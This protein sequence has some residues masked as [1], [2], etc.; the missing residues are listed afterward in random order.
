[1]IERLLNKKNLIS[2]GFF[3]VF[4]H[5]VLTFSHYFYP[6][7]WLNIVDYVFLGIMGFAA[8]LFFAKQQFQIRFQPA[9]M[10]L[11]AFIAWYIVSCLSMTITFH[12]DWV[13]YNNSGLL[14][15]AV[16]AV[17]AFSLGYITIRDGKKNPVGQILLHVLMLGWTLFIAY[18]LIVVFQGKEIITAS[19][20]FIGVNENNLLLNCNRNTT[21]AWEMLF[22]MGCCFMTMW[23]KQLPLKI[24]YGLSSAIH[25]I[26]LTLSNSRASF[27]AALI[28]FM[29]M[30][31]VAVYLRLNQGGKPHKILFAVVAAL[32]A[33]V[34]YYFVSNLVYLLYNLATGAEVSGRAFEAQA[35]TFSGREDVWRY[36]IQGIFSSLRS[37]IFGVTPASV[38][39]LILQISNY[40][41]R[42]AM[43]THN[44]FLEIAA[45]IGIP[46]LCIFLVWFGM[47]VRDSFKLYFVQ[48]DTTLMLMIPII[49]MALMLM[50]MME[51]LLVFYD[52]IHHYVFFLLCGL[53]YGR[54]NKP[55]EPKTLSRQELRNKERKKK[56]K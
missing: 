37:A 11:L 17:L 2:F 14:N 47:I 38:P 39:E 1:M 13:T 24:V 40:T 35:Q 5:A 51:A 19:G 46:G 56:K 49:I 44:Q 55:V 26:A 31:G 22:F 33:G 41:L 48:K 54:V 20:G 6:A 23:C 15:M 50:N 9:Q 27:L 16:S 25:Y 45:G 42:E 12:S 10:T 18:V 29:A 21:G 52:Y 32:A 43:Y 28:G 4:F 30:M 8:I 53:L 36:S 7:D 34:I 3:A